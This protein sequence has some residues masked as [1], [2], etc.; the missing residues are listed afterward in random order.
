MARPPFAI[1]FVSLLA[2][3]CSVAVYENEIKSFKD[4]TDIAASTFVAYSRGAGEVAARNDLRALILANKG[5]LVALSDDCDKWVN[6]QQAGRPC[7]VV[8]ND[9]DVT[10]QKDVGQANLVAAMKALSEYAGSLEAVASSKDIDEA[11]ASIGSLVKDVGGLIQKL[12]SAQAE[13]KSIEAAVGPITGMVTWVAGNYLTYKRYTALKQATARVQPALA[14]GRARLNEWAT[15]VKNDYAQARL[16]EF[17]VTSKLIKASASTDPLPI[18][19]AQQKYA[20]EV[21]AIINA[22]PNGMFD[23]MVDAHGALTQALDDPSRQTEALSKSIQAFKKAADDLAALF[24][25]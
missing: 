9:T 17:T 15:A 23:A 18:V 22:K 11:T 20:S 5:A 4:S 13:Q 12:P 10:P 16:V 1:V 6:G 19:I 7:R 24:T 8:V 2:A 14:G 25:K 3:G 21:A